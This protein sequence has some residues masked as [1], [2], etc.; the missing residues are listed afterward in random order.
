MNE[1]SLNGAWQFKS[2]TDV[3]WMDAAVPGDVHRD[4]L[5]KQKIEDPFFADNAEKCVW[6]EEKTWLYRKTFNVPEG[7][8][9]IMRFESV[10]RPPV[11]SVENITESVAN[12]LRGWQ[13]GM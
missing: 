6:I 13:Y 4:L 3:D 2:E 5:D 8:N 1:I 9:R 7:F 11:W 12:S 10:D